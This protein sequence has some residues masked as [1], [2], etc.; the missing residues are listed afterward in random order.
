MK[1]NDGFN[2]GRKREKR[3]E[4][5]ESSQV[6]RKIS[7]SHLENKLKRE[8]QITQ[9]VYFKLSIYSSSFPSSLLKQEVNFLP[10]ITL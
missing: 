1:I 4:K 5:D 9:F 3:D 2:S 10:S 6:T 8:K 7:K